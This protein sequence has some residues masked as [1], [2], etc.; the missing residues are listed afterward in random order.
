MPSR[1]SVHETFWYLLTMSTTPS[2]S[3]GMKTQEQKKERPRSDSP[4]DPKP[5]AEGHTQME[6]P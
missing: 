3:S 4:D 1:V 6:Y 2:I 5:A